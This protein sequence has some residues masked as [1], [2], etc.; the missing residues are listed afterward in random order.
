MLI[1]YPQGYL[2]CQVTERLRFVT[3]RLEA[4]EMPV[5]TRGMTSEHTGATA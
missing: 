3:A 2:V 1:A 4:D 5:Y